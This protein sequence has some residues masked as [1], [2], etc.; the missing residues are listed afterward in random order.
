MNLPDDDAFVARA[1]SLG[2]APDALAA[3]R[4]ELAARRRTGSLFDM[5][6]FAADF[7]ALAAQVGLG[8]GWRPD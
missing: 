5:D 2:N 1:I 8:H 7:A 4:A 3:L 6:G